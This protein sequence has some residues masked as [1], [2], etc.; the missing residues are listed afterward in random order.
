MKRIF[1]MAFLIQKR[2]LKKPSFLII[3]LLIPIVVFS[4]SKLSEKDTS[5]FK[6]AIYSGKDQGEA[7]ASVL[8]RISAYEDVLEYK[9]CNS[10]EEAKDAVINGSVDCAWIFPDDFYS[11][12]REY[13]EN[14]S[15]DIKF[16]SVYVREETVPTRLSGELLFGSVFPEISKEIYLDYLNNKLDLKDTVSNEEMMDVFNSIE[17]S[18][19]IIVFTDIDGN[20]IKKS[21]FLVSPIRGILSIFI[22]ISALA[23]AMYYVK[24]ADKGAFA[25]MPQRRRLFL[26]FASVFFGALDCAALSFVSLMFTSLFTSFLVEIFHML[27]LILTVS[28]FSSFFALLLGKPERI[29][30]FITFISVAAFVF[31]PVFFNFR[32]PFVSDILP[33]YYYLKLIGG[34]NVII[35]LLLFIMYLILTILLFYADKRK[36]R[37]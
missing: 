32:L 18:K 28:A 26:L 9:F 11:T 8:S 4:I 30:V 13:A 36:A 17:T 24:D 3:L 16:V 34:R 15:T 31:C 37:Q 23:S 22:M 12:V 10:P 1:T 25:I 6:A 29:G 21:N 5:I 2:L 27:L 35:E 20:E 14:P 33:Q 7:K 19:D